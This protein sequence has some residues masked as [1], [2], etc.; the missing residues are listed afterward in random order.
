MGKYSYAKDENGAWI[1]RTERGDW[2]ATT[3]N[4]RVASIIAATLSNSPAKAVVLLDNS[5]FRGFVTD[6]LVMEVV[7]ADVG[8]VDQDLLEDCV[9]IPH[10]VWGDTD[11]ILQESRASSNP[12]FVSAVFNKADKSDG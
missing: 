4:E 3:P 7:E 5:V 6:G 10:P 12:G 8:N 2:A 9:T 11:A 1:I